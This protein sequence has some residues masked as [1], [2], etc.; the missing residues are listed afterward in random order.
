MALKLGKYEIFKFQAWKGLTTENHLGAIFAES[1]NLGTNIMVELQTRYH[2]KNLEGFLRQFPIK[3]FDSDAEITWNVIGS[4]RR[5]IA[6]VEARD[7]TGAVVDISS[8]NVGVGGK[9]FYL[10]FAE[11]WFAFGETIVGERNEV[12]PFRIIAQPKSEGAYTVYKVE[13]MGGILE[14]CPAEE[15]QPG[16]RFSWEYAVVAKTMSRAV[17]DVR[18]STSS[19]MRND[20]TTIRIQHKVGGDMLDK[21]LAVGIPI[22]RDDGTRDTIN[23]WM[24]YEEMKVEETFREYK[25]NALMYGTSNRNRNGEY[26]NY[27]AG[28]YVIRQGS[29]LREQGQVA[30]TYYYNEFNLKFIE[31][32]L[33]DLSASKLD[34]NDRV[35]VMRTGEYG[36][37]QFSKAVLQTVS[38]WMAFGFGGSTANNPAIINKV[39]ST[40]H[41]NALA[42]GFQF[43]EYRAP[44]H[45]TLRVEV[46]P[47]YDDRVRNKI[48]M[49]GLGGPAESYRYDIFAIGTADQP[50][51]QLC[52]LNGPRGEEL[53]GFMSGM[54]NP[55]TGATS[56][57][58]M[59]TDEDSASIHRQTTFSVMVLDPTRMISIIPVAL[60]A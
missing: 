13:L 11:D 42:A 37:A 10:V 36:A 23:K 34:M 43:V 1:P 7:E 17:G 54:R 35:F 51:I 59:S 58:F 40:L 29:G 60:R 49:P 25:N 32:A 15:L 41:D 53:R 44:N 50:N 24:F 22:V 31:D 55:F 21:K 28:G 12:Y 16:K 27:D 48:M 6:L 56:N 47:I 5:N 30:G 18:F 9:P 39:N 52:A 38:G 26:L 19:A 3:R 14:G 8:D 57:Y 2:G 20:W 33:M 46:D 45:V 4:S